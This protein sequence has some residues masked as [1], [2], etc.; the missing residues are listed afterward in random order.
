MN[1]YL[2]AVLIFIIGQ[3]LLHTM[4]AI[5]SIRHLQLEIPTEFMGFAD[6]DRYRQSQ[7]YF[8]DTTSLQL[9]VDTTM[10]AL[11]LLML[12]AG[13]FNTIDSMVRGLGLG[14]VSS[15]VLYIG[16]MAL[17]AHML[18]IPFDAYRTFRIEARYGFNRTRPATFVADIL[19]SWCLA[20]LLGGPLVAAI[21]WFFEQA[22]AWAWL[23]CWMTITGLQLL[24]VFIAPVA[25]MPLFNR[26]EPLQA[27]PLK[28]A[29]EAYTRQQRFKMKGV[30]TMDGSRRS[31]KANA[32]FTGF[33]RY[34]RIV[35]FDTLIAQHSVDEL[36]AVV[37]H[38]IGHYKQRHLLVHMAIATL[39]TG[40]LLLIL[41]Q[42]IN[43]PGLF[44]AFQME[45]LSVYASL[46]F[47]GFL[48]TPLAMVLAL[49]S[50]AV[51]RGHEHAADRFAAATTGQA[52]AM[53]TAL[54]KLTVGNLS[55]LTPH[56]LLVAL[57]HSHPP[58]LERIKRI[59]AMGRPDEIP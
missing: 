23:Y 57:C 58:V 36:V 37:A 45:H 25:I 22:S 47:F 55:N 6:P 35:L 41:A 29:L 32:F 7:F 18:H 46:V 51:S 40:G 16:F 44:A 15:G 39:T 50:N 14:M 42:F 31:T 30:F 52:E 54:K 21:I 1:P 27:G 11:I 53:I 49:L 8:K 5:V 3:Y 56:P 59:R 19:K 48:Y 38:E 20:G 26:F 24:L 13:G 34:R 28:T 4:L 17:G 2:I 10:T 12:G 33:G 9:V 43:N